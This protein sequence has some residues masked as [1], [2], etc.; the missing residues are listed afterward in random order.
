MSYLGKQNEAKIALINAIALSQHALARILS[1]IADVSSHSEITARS[2]QEN[3]RLLTEYQSRM[4]QMITR[5]P[6]QRYKCGTPSSPW[7]NSSQHSS[8]NN[9]RVEQG[10]HE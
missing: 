1:S 9:L 5:I 2:L 10:S 8:L 7:L 4:S 6:L 3:I